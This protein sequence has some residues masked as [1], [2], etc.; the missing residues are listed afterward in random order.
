MLVNTSY[1]IEVPKTGFPK[2]PL[3]SAENR[4]WWKEQVKRCIEGYSVGGMYITGEHYYYLNFKKIPVL[5]DGRTVLGNPLF[6]DLDYEFFSLI[7]K[8]WD[9]KVGF[10]A[11]KAR[12]KGFSHKTAACLENR[13]L[14]YPDS[15]SLICSYEE[16]YSTFGTMV[17]VKESLKRLKSEGVRFAKNLYPDQPDYIRAAYKDANNEERGYMSKIHSLTFRNNIAAAAG[18]QVIGYCVFEEA[19]EF[20]NLLKAYGKTEPCWK[21]GSEMTGIP[22]IYG[23]GG[24]IE[25]GC[26]DFAEMFYNPHKYN[27]LSFKN[28][29]STEQPDL[30]VGYFCPA[31]KFYLPYVD[32]HGNSDEESAKKAIL[33]ERSKL[34]NTNDPQALFN[35]CISYPLTPEQAFLATHPSPFNKSKIMEQ[36]TFM[37]RKSAQEM[38]VRGNLVWKHEN[39]WTEVR[40][41]PS[42]TGK[43]I[44]LEHPKKCEP[45]TYVAGVDPYAQDKTYSSPS[46]GSMFVFKRL[47]S[48]EE[49]YNLPVAEYTDR[50]STEDEFLENCCKLAVYY[51]AKMLFEANNKGWF[52]FFRINHMLQWLLPEPTPT[53]RAIT[54]KHKSTFKYGVTMTPALKQDLILR[55]KDYIETSVHKI[56]FMDLLKEL[57]K[58]HEG[59]NFDRF[60]SF[61]L[62]L[63]HDTSIQRAQK[64]ESIDGTN[65]EFTKY[66]IERGRIIRK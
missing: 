58:W 64:E 2:A 40:F 9:S 24:D 30:E 3:K 19:G 22:I 42:K 12:R 53:I 5:K 23:T 66:R 44:I 38:L 20:K 43:F 46:V 57:L 18:K 60:I 49:P 26:E 15:W 21:V 52:T 39:N 1:F 62:C 16:K 41:E 33:E 25:E 48:V 34:E 56:Y 47:I 37:N 10:I 32:E 61:A 54:P 11:L 55:V 51:N 27:L 45:R 65:A 6:T 29:Y 50:P 13:F 4:E 14:F 7:K 35:H 36:I 8:C 28:S 63:L 17:F 59:G 31:T